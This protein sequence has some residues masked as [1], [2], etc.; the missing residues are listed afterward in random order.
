MFGSRFKRA[1]M[2]A[3]AAAC[4]V[5]IA[6]CGGLTEAST[7]SDFMKASPQAQQSIV[8][9][10]AGKY[11][12]PDFATPLGMPEVPYYCASHPSTSLRQF[13]ALA[14]D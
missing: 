9:N 7:C 2:V 12:K 3:G 6:G 14:Q 10:L 13:F 4:A 8:L 5:W 1:W 11:Q